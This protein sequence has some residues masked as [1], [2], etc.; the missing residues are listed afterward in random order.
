M[1]MTAARIAALCVA[2]RC[3]RGS[4]VFVPHL[5]SR[6]VGGDVRAKQQPSRRQSQRVLSLA[7]LELRRL[8]WPSTR[9]DGR[10]GLLASSPQLANIVDVVWVRSCGTE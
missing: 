7:P 5:A 9:H 4:A 2:P 8:C 3:A 1:G 6:A 10:G